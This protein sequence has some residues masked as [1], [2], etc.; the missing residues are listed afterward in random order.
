M[1]IDNATNLPG[2]LDGKVAVVT[3]AGRG[4]GLE[5]ARMLARLGAIVII[6]EISQQGP[7]AKTLIRK[8]GG[9]AIYV[10]TDVGSS[11]S[12]WHLH[13]AVIS[14]CGQVDI[15]VNNA[16]VFSFGPLWKQSLEDWD[17][18]MAVNLRGA[19][20]CTKAFLPGMLERKQG[21]IVTMDSSEGMPYLA[22]YLASKAGLR[23]LAAS[24]AHEVGNQSGVSVFCYSPGMVDTPGLR[25]ALKELPAMYGTTKDEFIAQSGGF[26]ISA[27]ASAAGLVG[28]ILYAQ[29]YHGLEVGYATGLARIGL[30]VT[31]EPLEPS[32]PT[33]EA[34]KNLQQRQR[35]E[36]AQEAEDEV[37]EHKMLPAELEAALLLNK[38]LE[39]ILQANIRE[40]SE[41]S[42]FQR[43]IVRRMFQQ[44]A[45]M[46]VEEWLANAEEMSTHLE[47][48]GKHPSREALDTYAAQLERLAK[49]ILKQET[50]A[51]GFFKNQADLD[52]ALR[53]L[54]ERR[55]VV[56]RLGML[57]STVAGT[58]R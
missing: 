35:V 19:F 36:L 9:R 41:L 46:S 8:E 17:R 27:E 40:Y 31:G 34:T 4:I 47:S 30:T 16:V 3:G 44:H 23:S 7:Q 49:F 52:K 48:R 33:T 39:N 53:A 20:L 13:D 50:D 38:K 1:I 45:G 57:I 32:S 58:L 5:A 10:H 42:M 43:P 28:A 6:A 29:D 18:V 12:V 54:A 22:P 21:V 51:R 56:T 14:T 55:E 2:R 25:Q 37:L 26:M 24:L 15:L 11:D